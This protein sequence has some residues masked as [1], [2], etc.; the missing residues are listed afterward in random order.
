MESNPTGVEY[1]VYEGCEQIGR[2]DTVILRGEVVVENGEYLDKP[3]FGKFVPGKAV[4]TCIR[5]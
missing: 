4:R 5:T 3:V 2:A 1:N